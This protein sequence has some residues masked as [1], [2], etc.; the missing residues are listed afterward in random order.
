VQK[1]RIM[2]MLIRGDIY[3]ASEMYEAVMRAREREG[4]ACQSSLPLWAHEL[5][6]YLRDVERECVVALFPGVIPVRHDSRTGLFCADES[7]KWPPTVTDIRHSM[8]QGGPTP[9]PPVRDRPP[10]PPPNRGRWHWLRI[11]G[12]VVLFLLYALL[13][14]ASAQGGRSAASPSGSGGARVRILHLSL[15]DSDRRARFVLE[16]NT[17]WEIF[18]AGCRERLQVENIRRVADSSGGLILAVEDVVHDDHL[19]IYATELAAGEVANGDGTVPFGTMFALLVLWFGI[20]VP[21]VFLSAQLLWL[22]RV[23]ST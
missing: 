8:R 16:E 10:L 23:S 7:F 22:Y 13:L 17:G 1:A 15:A 5:R 4:E 9:H 6:V 19:V 18:L 2:Q 11:C 3:E 14:Y 12:A 21:L 20:S